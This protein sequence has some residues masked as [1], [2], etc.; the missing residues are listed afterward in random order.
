MRDT[1]IGISSENLDWVMKPFAR[2]TSDAFVAETPGVGLG[3]PIARSLM[4]L[5]HGSLTLTS[6]PGQ[7]TL[8]VLRLPPE[9]VVEG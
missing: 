8:V 5:H 9:R 7:G 3:L 6:T 2:E 1:G 4:E